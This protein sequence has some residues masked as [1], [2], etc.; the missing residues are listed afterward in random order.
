MCYPARRFYLENKHFTR[1]QYTNMQRRNFIKN[2]A[3]YAVAVSA[4]GFIR[5]DGKHY[6]GDCETTTDIIGPFYRPGSPVRNDLVVP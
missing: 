1:L 5:F 4:Y 6:V 2:T 3:F